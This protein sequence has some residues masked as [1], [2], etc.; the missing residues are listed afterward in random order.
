MENEMKAT[1]IFDAL[2]LPAQNSEPLENS[3]ELNTGNEANPVNDNAD[4]P[5]VEEPTFKASDLKAI[6]SKRST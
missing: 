3:P 2:G 4:T 1:S 5:P 6:L